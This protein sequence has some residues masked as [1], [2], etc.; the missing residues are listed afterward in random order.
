[1]DLSGLCQG[2]L[3]DPT[4]ARACRAAGPNGEVVTPAA[5]VP[6]L[7]AGMARHRTVVAITATG[8]QAEDLASAASSLVG[9]SRVAVLP[10]WETLPHE[11]LSPS[12]DT[13]GRRLAVLRRLAH[14]DPDDETIGALDLVVAPVRA[15]LQPLVVGLGELV[16]VRVR[17]GDEISPEALATAL[18]GVGYSPT[19]LVEKRGQFAVRGGIVDVFPPTEEHPVR[20]EF[21]GDDVEEIRYFRVVDQRSLEV[22]GH[23]LWAPPCRELLLTETVRARAA[24]LARAHPDLEEM[25]DK[26]AQG[27]AVEGMEAL[28]PL[29]ADGMETLVELV[30]R[31]AGS[32]PMVLLC[33]PELV[34]TR[35]GELVATSNEFLAASW[36][37]AAVGNATP[38]DLGAAAYRSIEEVRETAATLGVAWWTAGPFGMAAVGEADEGQDATDPGPAPAEP[39]T[40]PRELPADAIALPVTPT[41]AYRG[42]G[43]ALVADLRAALRAGRRVVAVTAGLGSAQRLAEQLAAEDVPAR[44]VPG[45]TR[46]PP[47]AGVVT[48]TTGRL[49]HGLEAANPGLL[50]VTETDIRGQKGSRDVTRM[51]SRRRNTVDPLQLAA[52]D[53][54]VHEQHGVG[55]YVEMTQRTVGGATREYLVIE[56]AP[57]KRGQPPD[58]LYVPSDQLD[59]V[60]RYVGGEAP[61]VHRLGGSDW[62]Q[63][64]TRARK[65]VRQIAGELVKLYATRQQA[66]GYAFGPDSPWQAEL[67]DAFAY[68]ET[69]DQWSTIAEVKADMEKAVPMDRLVCGDVGYGKTEIAVRAAFKAVQDG[70]QVAV[71]V[72]TTLLV[73]QHLQTFADRYEGFPVKVAGLSRFQTDSEARAVLAGLADGTVDVVIGTHRLFGAQTRFKDLGPAHRRRGAALRR[74]AQGAHQGP[75]DQRR[76]AHDVGHAHP[77][78]PGDGG[79][80][81]PGDVDHPDP[82]RG[83]PPGA[84]LRGG[85]RP[86][87]DL[88]GDPPRA[89]CATARCSSCTT[90]WSPSSGWP[91][92]CA[93]SCPRPGSPPRTAR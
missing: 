48:V 45:I 62:Q 64:K 66:V 35:A 7:A 69:P 90:G 34:R 58:R 1:M 44:V 9:P 8:R 38:I 29:L 23:G 54:V 89:A 75:A 41:P 15:L 86:E 19:D 20:V 16:P 49:D 28:S 13:V 17:P 87:A 10:A 60:T 55:R 65:A 74:G 79:H 51:P 83:A 11:R 93:T 36:H 92:P 14:P 70:K 76:R 26:L 22:A 2:L 43:R 85:L 67:E 71:L 82:A 61:S 53:H 52:G 33:D 59:Q 68:T 84:D 27:I 46:W 3:E 73:Q 78:H 31:T 25:C 12:S 5:A 42:D 50:I 4:F 57:S 63:A 81:D 30:H 39:G 47:G 32:D 91:R 37:N 56:Y 21:W 77:A 24:A 88:C 6:F 40:A 18:V 80:R 72:P